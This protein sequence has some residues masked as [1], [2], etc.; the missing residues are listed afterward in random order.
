[1]D[2]IRAAADADPPLTTEQRSRLAGLLA[3]VAVHV[4]DARLAAYI[5]RVVDAA[6]PLTPEQRDRLAGLLRPTAG[7]PAT[8]SPMRPPV[9]A[10]PM[11][12]YD[13]AALY[14]YYDAKGALLYI[15]ITNCDDNRDRGHRRDA[16]WY[17]F[18]VRREDGDAFTTRHAALDAERE[19]IRSENPIFN[20]QHAGPE[21]HRRAVTYLVEHNEWDCLII[22]GL[23]I[24]RNSRSVIEELISVGQFDAIEIV[25]LRAEGTA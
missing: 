4:S 16:I 24:R 12:T 15:G 6:P 25:G 17:Q 13:V 8:D 20:R 19:A 9:V 11:P 1:M 3:P 18:V 2:E 14:R 7:P 22:K 23:N 10:P 5:A 21:G